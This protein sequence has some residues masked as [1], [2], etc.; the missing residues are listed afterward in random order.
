MSQEVHDEVAKLD[1]RITNELKE[2]AGTYP[3]EVSLLCKVGTQFFQA[4]PEFDFKEEELVDN[5]KMRFYGTLKLNGFLV[6]KGYGC[7]KKVVK[8]VAA[9]LALMNLTPTLFKQ[10]KAQRS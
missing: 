4:V 6:G 9:R 5:P 8:N 1:L 3:D 2:V 7:N 10:W